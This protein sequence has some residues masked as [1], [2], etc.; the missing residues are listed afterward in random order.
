MHGA[1]VH[2]SAGREKQKLGAPRQA[3]DPNNILDAAGIRKITERTAQENIRTNELRQKERR[4][5]LAQ[6]TAAQERE[7]RLAQ[8]R[9]EAEARAKQDITA[10]RW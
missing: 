1:T 7:L 2:R 8:E 9:A 3:L 4:E 6:N 10:H 5:I